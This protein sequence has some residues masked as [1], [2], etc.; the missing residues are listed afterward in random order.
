MRTKLKP[1]I[2]SLS[3]GEGRGTVSRPLQFSSRFA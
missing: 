2:L 3:K 1:L